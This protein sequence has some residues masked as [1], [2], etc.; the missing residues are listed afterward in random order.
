MSDFAPEDVGGVAII[1]QLLAAYGA[2]VALVPADTI[3]AGR[4]PE[5]CPLPNLLV[6][7][8]SVVDRVML[9]GFS[10]FVRERVQVTVRASNYA[11][12]K[13]I[14]GL[15]K[16]ACAGQ[17]GDFGQLT[18]ASVISAGAGPDFNDEST[19]I[20]MGSRDFIVSYNEPA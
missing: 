6:T 7:T 4:L 14:L 1:G 5:N 9:S 19:S 12:R 15:A 10:A 2:L 3:K 18:R 8:V 16:R 20:Y 17:R 11:D 13:L